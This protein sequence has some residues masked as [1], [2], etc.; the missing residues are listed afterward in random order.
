MLVRSGCL[1][2]LLL[3]GGIAEAKQPAILSIEV[4]AGD[5]VGLGGGGVGA[6]TLRMSPMTLSLVADY[7]IIAYPWVSL[8]GGLRG[9]TIGRAGIGGIIGFRLRPARGPLRI[10][11]ALN[12]MLAPYTLAGP[13]GTIGA[14][15]RPTH[16]GWGLCGDL[17]ITA[18]M[19][20]NDLPPGR[21][22]A[23]GAGLLGVVFDAL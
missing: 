12:T 9:E 5:G 13:A 3:L 16:K 15:W 22:V 20:G 6:L 23:Q 1:M 17:E 19:M 4:S 2:F 8:Y 10:G 14:C 18:F 21:V 11:I 7:A